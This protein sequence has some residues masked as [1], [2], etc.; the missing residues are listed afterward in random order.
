M[1]IFYKPR[2]RKFV[3]KQTRSFQLAIE[4]EV[5]RI[6]IDPQKGEFKKGDLKGFQV[7]KFYYGK[8]HFIIAYRLQERE[9]MFYMIGSH[10]NFYR[11]LK[12]YLRET[13]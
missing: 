13:E 3:K 2:F 4:D 6:I 8:K 1:Q 12:R 9:I 11:E 5:E 10:E 7:H